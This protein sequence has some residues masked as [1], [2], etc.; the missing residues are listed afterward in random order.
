MEE[1][2]ELPTSKYIRYGNIYSY[3][4][5]GIDAYPI[6]IESDIH[7]GIPKF[8]IV[9]LPSSSVKESRDR[10]TAAIRNSG[11]TFK[12]FVYTINLAPADLPKDGVATDLPIALAI[13]KASQQLQYPHKLKYAFVGELALNGKLRPVKGVLPMVM[14]AKKNKLDAIILPKENEKEASI[15]EGVNI[16]GVSTLQECV[17]FLQNEIAIK[18]T[19]FNFDKNALTPKQSLDMFDVKGQLQI[20]RA[21]EIAAAGGHNIL[22]IGPPGSGKTMLAKRLTSILP[23]MSLEEILQTTKIY[24]IAGK[25]IDQE[26]NIVSTRPF[27]SPHHTISDIALI[28]GGSYPK[29]GE[30]SLAHNGV[31][32]L[33]ELPEFKKNVLEVL[34][35]PLEDGTVCIARANST[36]SFPADFMLVASMNPCPCGYYGSD[37]VGHECTCSPSAIQRYRSRISG[38]LL[39]RFDIHIEVG[40]LKYEELEALP[41]GE[42]SQKI[43]KR[44]NDVRSRQRNKLKGIFS[45]SQMLPEHL[46][47]YCQIDA[48]SSQI[49][50][51]AIEQMGLSARA[52]DKI[53]KISRTIADMENSENI[54]SHH[55]SEAIQYR[56]LDRKFWE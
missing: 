27:R 52:Y 37:L 44:V 6:Q 10:V 48:E 13:L 34:R 56:S 35:Q 51:N 26:E 2:I 1:Y 47:K 7:S 12:P 30:V 14:Q 32:F 50:K 8:S 36:L 46:R 39:D 21:L 20:K 55:I 53:L 4:L 41:C 9:G 45:N 16:I 42:P 54:Q 23:D 11:F 22:M 43:R 24:S 29:P 18:P 25:L 19:P 40:A 5:L 49:L 17:R 15:V 28:G 31:L 3:S 33:D 38:P